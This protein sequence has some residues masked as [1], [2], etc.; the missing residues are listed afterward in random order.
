M[1]FSLKVAF[2]EKESGARIPGEIRPTIKSDLVDWLR[3][4]YN[5]NDED[6]TW[7]WFEIFSASQHS[8]TFECFSATANGE[9][10]GFAALDLRPVRTGFGEAITLD[11]LA[12]NPRNR[13]R[14]SGLKYVGYSLVAAAVVRSF[15]GGFN[16][17]LR[18]ESL[19]GAC[20]FY[21]NLGM[22]RQP[23][24]S[25]DRNAVYCLDAATAQRLLER[26]QDQAI[27]KI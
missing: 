23:G 2:T 1:N 8:N 9:L 11:Y 26:I 4:S 13:T 21:E 10:Q 3:W 7:N 27:L 19:P 5:R 17:V 18:L 20:A 16:G 14:E 15:L 12:T 6:R 22:Q 24:F 25:Q